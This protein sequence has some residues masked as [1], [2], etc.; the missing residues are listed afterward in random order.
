MLWMPSA[1][2]RSLALGPMPLILRA[3][4]GQMRW[5][6]SSA[7]SSVRPSGLSRSE[8]IFAS[9]LLAAMLVGAAQS[10]EVGWHC[11]CCRVID[12]L[13]QQWRTVDQVDGQS[14]EFVFV[15]KIAPQRVVWLQLPQR[16]ESQALQAPG[17]ETGGVGRAIVDVD[18]HAV[19]ELAGVLVESRLEP[20]F[21]QSAAEQPVRCQG[22]HGF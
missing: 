5:V 12:P 10:I 21:A 17:A 18:L 11:R 20:A 13:A 6:R 4:S 7:F 9:S 1:A 14:L 19:A 2:S 8:P 3:G 15:G 22:V 16:L